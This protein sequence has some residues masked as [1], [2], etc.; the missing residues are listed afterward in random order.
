M[1]PQQFSV[2]RGDKFGYDGNKKITDTK[3]LIVLSSNVLPVVLVTTPINNHDSIKFVEMMEHILN[4]VT[5]DS[6]KQIKHCFADK[7]NDSATIR[8]E[9]KN[10]NMNHHI[11]VK[12][13]NTAPHAKKTILHLM[14][15]K[16]YC[17]SW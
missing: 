17:T 11:P 4:F 5:C 8:Q 10:R 3:Q 2:R 16:Q 9:L 6:I 14:L 12:K 1:I 13:N 7:A 15:K